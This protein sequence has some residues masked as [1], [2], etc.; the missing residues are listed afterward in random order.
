MRWEGRGGREVGDTEEGRNE[1]GHS[2]SLMLTSNVCST[3]HPNLS[4]S[5]LSLAIPLAQMGADVSASDISDAMSSEAARRAESLG[6]SNANFYTSDLESVEVRMDEGAN[7][8][9]RW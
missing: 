4:S 5:T 1:E 3:Y 9:T 2:G 7:R 6:I 8:S